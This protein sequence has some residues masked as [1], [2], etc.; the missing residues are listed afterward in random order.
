M[1]DAITFWNWFRANS[2]D[3]LKLSGDEISAEKTEKLLD[4]LL[5]QL[6]KYCDRL[7]FDIGG[8]SGEEQELIITAEGNPEYFP[9][10]EELINNAP[11][12]KNWQFIAFMQPRGLDYT[13][14]FEDIELIPSDL[15][16]LPLDNPGKPK[17]IGLRICLP[18]YESVKRSKWLKAAVFKMLDAM[19]GEKAFALD[20]DY[21]DIGAL[22]NN[23]EEHGMMELK[24]LPAFIKWKKA[25]LSD[26]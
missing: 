22:P 14:K 20:L 2:E 19:L 5:D 21:I 9:F 4:E 23:P 16:F 6:H 3:L 13:S 26:L 7:Y 15:W 25:K 10:V 24:D 1:A 11:I 8:Q 12:I 18:N 17:S